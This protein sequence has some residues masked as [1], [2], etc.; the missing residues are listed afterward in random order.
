MGTGDF[1]AT[2][3]PIGERV[4]LVEGKVKGLEKETQRTFQDVKGQLK[5]G[6]DTMNGINTTLA[7]INERMVT[8]G[9]CTA[10]R[11]ACQDARGAELGSLDG[12]L[13]KIEHEAALAEQARDLTNPKIKLPM[14][15]G[16]TPANAKK[17]VGVA[18]AVL[19]LLGFGSVSTCVNSTMGDVQSALQRNQR[20]AAAGQ[21][22][23]RNQIE[24][25]KEQPPVQVALPPPVVVPKSELTAEERRHLE[26]RRRYLRYRAR[27]RARA[28]RPPRR[29]PASQPIR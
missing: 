25:L 8:K 2:P 16:L 14:N 5:E 9:D 23:L 11:K 4:A 12:R 27:I 29:A 13:D 10:E 7:I 20:Q 18:V 19:G 22:D 21:Q 15:N 3:K 6:H 17:W 24:V 28:K 26:R 1:P